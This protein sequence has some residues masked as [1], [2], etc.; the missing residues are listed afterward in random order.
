MK[1]NSTIF[2]RAKIRSSQGSWR[3][4]ASSLVLWWLTS[5]TTYNI[6]IITYHRLSK[7]ASMRYHL[8]RA[9]L[10]RR[11]AGQDPRGKWLTLLSWVPAIP[12][13]P[14]W[15]KQ[16]QRYPP[17][18]DFEPTDPPPRATDERTNREWVLTTMLPQATFQSP[19]VMFHGGGVCYALPFLW[20]WP[21]TPEMVQSELNAQSPNGAHLTRFAYTVFYISLTGIKTLALSHSHS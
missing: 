5:I 12:R 4:R 13:G 7:T 18:P 15:R 11:R 1:R 3:P 8:L 16:P 9:F 2:E 17:Q 19:E 14:L 10:I 20:A 21:R 6:R